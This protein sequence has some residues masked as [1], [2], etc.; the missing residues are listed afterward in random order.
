MKNDSSLLRGLA[1]GVAPILLLGIVT[2]LALFGD[3]G[4]PDDTF[5]EL[6]PPT[7][8]PGSSGTSEI[9]T[10]TWDPL[11]S[12][13]SSSPPT[14]VA[15]WP[16]PAPTASRP[17][18]SRT[19][20]REPGG[21]AG[22]SAPRPVRQVDRPLAGFRFTRVDNYLGPVERNRSNGEGGS[23]DGHT[24]SI[25]GVRFSAGLG[26]HAPSRVEIDLGGRCSTFSTYIGLDDEEGEDPRKN[27]GAVAFAVAGD[28]RAL[29]R[30]ST[31]R[32]NDGPQA[33]RVDVSGIRTLALIVDELDSTKNDHA[34][35]A[36][37]T[38]R[39]AA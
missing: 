26:V 34:D 31:V 23:H 12:A 29:Y 35:W 8:E 11:P 4:E 20:R 25:E 6:P 38:L 33:V 37:A 39:C 13:G 24:M 15:A 19:P 3:S 7:S 14:E 30:S 17:S 28:G 18:V 21:H 1:I 2:G 27:V 16:T 5:V 10:A 36:G 9:G 32:P 22:G